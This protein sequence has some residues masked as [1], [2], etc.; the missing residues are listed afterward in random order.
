MALS[1]IIREFK[2]IS[3]F[4]TNF[5]FAIQKPLIIYYNNKNIIIFLDIKETIYYY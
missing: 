1:K 5:E 3:I 4:M 2:W